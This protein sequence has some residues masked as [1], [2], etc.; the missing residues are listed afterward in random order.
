[1]QEH[2][3]DH[4]RRMLTC[5]AGMALTNQVVVAKAICTDAR[6]IGRAGTALASAGTASG[7]DHA[8]T[9]YGTGAVD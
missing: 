2:P 8:G 9:H 5:R 6:H 3:V 7:A 4:G 1:M